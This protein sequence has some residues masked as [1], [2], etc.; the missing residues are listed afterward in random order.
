MCFDLYVYIYGNLF[1][2]LMSQV[3]CR[4]FRDLRVPLWQV[5]CEART[6]FSPCRG[7]GSHHHLLLIKWHTPRRAQ[8]KRHQLQQTKQWLCGTGPAALLRAKI[9]AR[10]RKICLNIVNT[11]P[12]RGIPLIIKLGDRCA[13]GKPGYDVRQY[14][15]TTVLQLCSRWTLRN[16]PMV[17]RVISY[18]LTRIFPLRLLARAPLCV[19]NYLI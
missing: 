6:C 15:L 13:A 14:F 19:Q 12:L 1:P 17:H 2:C 8:R 11:L 5:F 4:R 7:R 10:L 18:L 3:G 9:N 16:F